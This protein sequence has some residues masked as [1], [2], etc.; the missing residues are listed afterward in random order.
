M[1]VARKPVVELSHVLM[2]KSVLLDRLPKG[3]QLFAGRQ[4]AV[5]QQIRRFNEVAVLS[6]DIDRISA[7]PQ[8]PLVAIEVGDLAI[9][10]PVLA[11][12]SS[13]V[14][15]PVV[16]SSWPMSIARSFSVPT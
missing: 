13:S 15:W 6:Q 9:V 16:F 11:K 4:L 12:P 5:N 8:N 14:M 7:V 2:E 1:R 3:L 10:E